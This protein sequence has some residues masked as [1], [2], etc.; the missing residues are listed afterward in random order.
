[1][2]GDEHVQCGHVHRAYLFEGPNFFLFL[3]Y[4]VFSPNV[5]PSTLIVVP[6]Q[7]GQG[8]ISQIAAEQKLIAY[9]IYNFIRLN[10]TK[11]R[12]RG[13]RNLRHISRHYLLCSFTKRELRGEIVNII[14][15]WGRI[16]F[17]DGD[18]IF[19]F[20]D[21]VYQPRFQ[22][23]ALGSKKSDAE[24]LLINLLSGPFFV[25]FSNSSLVSLIAGS[26]DSASEESMV[27]DFLEDG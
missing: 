18:F 2:A 11:Q 9:N 5:N 19:L 10:N 20:R 26:S 3:L 25:C 4:S 6:T 7:E 12:S 21:W 15:C 13:F 14:G 22:L 24:R 8:S 1:M 27:S 16:T 17:K 23:K